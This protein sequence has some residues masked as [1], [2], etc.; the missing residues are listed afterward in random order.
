MPEVSQPNSGDEGFSWSATSYGDY[1]FSVLAT[2]V[3]NVID[4]VGLTGGI[5]FSFYYKK[6]ATDISG[7][8]SFSSSPADDAGHFVLGY[9]DPHKTYYS[10]IY[11]YEG[12]L[13]LK[14]T[15][16]GIAGSIGSLTF[17]GNLAFALQGIGYQ[18]STVNYNATNK[19][20]TAGYLRPISAVLYAE[21]KDGHVVVL[22]DN[23]F[24]TDTSVVV[25]SGDDVTYQING[26]VS[27]VYLTIVYVDIGTKGF[28]SWNNGTN[29]GT[30]VTNYRTQAYFLANTQ[31]GGFDGSYGDIP[32]WEDAVFE[33]RDF[34]AAIFKTSFP[35]I[36]DKLDAILAAIKSQDNASGFQS[37]VNAVDKVNDTLTSSPEDSSAA[38]DFRDN[39]SSK[40]DTIDSMAQEIE[41]KQN[42]P[43]VADVVPTMPSD[44]IH[45]TDVA[46]VDGMQAV[47]D[48]LATPLIL[49]MLMV[50]FGLAF[51]RY[52]IF[53]KSEG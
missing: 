39:V 52:V 20:G 6:A 32:T 18:G 1:P 14:A 17:K 47:S 8:F 49:Q 22:D 29:G 35:G 12:N 5:N 2:P 45:P 19:Y 25:V 40:A 13:S 46:A 33:I 37:V 15:F 23:L 10:S 11:T 4:V 21:Y 34:V 7:S 44:V 50:V 42:R 26:D 48:I 30:Q 24:L 51:L 43:A 9:S 31:T 16:A 41:E 3:S 28:Y 38:S 36:S 53:G 27:S